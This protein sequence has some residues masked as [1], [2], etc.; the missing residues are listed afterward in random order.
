M[1]QG[2]E[3]LGCHCCGSGYSCGMGL[4]PCPG[5]S[6]CG[7]C[8]QNEKKK[9]KE[10]GTTTCTIEASSKEIDKQYLDPPFLLEALLGLL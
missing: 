4:I 6:S 3:D 2:G 10:K 1:A 9:K 5:T 8:G 7:G